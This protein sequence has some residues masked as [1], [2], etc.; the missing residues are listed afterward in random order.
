MIRRTISILSAL[1]LWQL[2]AL[3][4]DSTVFPSPLQCSLSAKES[5]LDGSLQEN[6]LATLMRVAV[7]YCMAS[8][9]GLLFGAAT[10]V[11]GYFGRSVRDVLEILRPIPPIAWVP[12][13]IVWFGLGNPSAW[14]VVFIGAFF[15]IY[16]QVTHAF[17]NPPEE[18]IDVARVFRANSWETF[19]WVRVPAATPEIVQ[20]LRVGLGLAWTSVI[21]AEL[22][23]VH[24]GL[25]DRINQLR[26][27]SDYEGMVVCMATIGILGWG[28]TSMANHLERKVNPWKR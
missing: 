4:L 19:W 3:L 15:P 28:M 27:V 17:A 5:I 10:G 23:G 22:V 7:G 6:A 11:S 21:A 14:F 1:L 9:A 2:F 26:F 13:A 16:I 20:G 24:R 25:G 8:V 12:L 18:F